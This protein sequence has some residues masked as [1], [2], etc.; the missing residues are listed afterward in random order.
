M[1]PDLP[2]DLS[3][4]ARAVLATAP[5]DRL[6]F[7]VNR[8]TALLMRAVFARRRKPDL[9]AAYT[10]WPT[11]TTPGTVAGHPVTQLRPPALPAGTD[12]TATDHLVYV[13]GGGFVVGAPVDPLVVGLT[14]TTGLPCTSV[15]YPFA[16]VARYPLALDRV[17]EVWT[18][19]ARR[20]TGRLVLGGTSAGG[21]LVLGLL[22]RLLARGAQAR[23]P[24]AVVL[25]TPAA[26][27]HEPGPSDLAN[28]GVDPMIR[29]EG[30]TDISLA[31]YIGGV[32]R[33]DPEISPV[34]GDYRGLTAPTLL[35]TGSTDLLHGVVHQ[36]ADV[37]RE[38]GVPVEVDDA[39]GMWHA[40]QQWVEIPEARASI[41]RVAAFV[42]RVL[43]AP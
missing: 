29:W 10:R 41:E 8:V 18:E 28:E 11:P 36:L 13:H 19:I 37:L 2:P 14:A 5:P 12:L 1:K 32:D 39:P 26:D 24:D 6:P 17:D 23:L 34:L 3:D 22:Q 9:D 33:D 40:Y 42:R 20:H 15:H 43:E 7:A 21:N 38:Q 35:V 30:M 31:A 25:F 27:M 16:P 4:Q